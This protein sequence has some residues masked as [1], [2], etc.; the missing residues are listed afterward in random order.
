MSA[1]RVKTGFHRLGI[2]LGGP[3]VLVSIATL[4]WGGYL[5]LKPI[6]S[7]PKWEISH[8]DGRKTVHVYGRDLPQL[9]GGVKTE[10]LRELVRRT[11]QKIASERELGS[12]LL[13][14]CVLSGIVA[15]LLYGLCR[16]ISWVATGFLSDREQRH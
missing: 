9:E 1:S 2:L 13:G 14:V 5:W 10:A 11:Q 7:P 15:G 8:L 6:L 3:F 4:V 12:L 16:G